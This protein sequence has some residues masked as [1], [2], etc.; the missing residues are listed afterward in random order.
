MNRRRIGVLGL[1][2]DGAS[3]FQRGP[4]EAPAAIRQA[5]RS[6]HSNQWAERGFDTGAAEAWHDLGDLALPDDAA[7]CR[8]AVEA[9]VARALEQDFTPLLLGGDHS[10]SYPILRAF[11]G[12][13]GS[14]Q[15][16]HFDAHSDLYDHLEGDRYSHACPFAR[17]LE[18]GLAAGMT[19][20]GIRTMNGHQREQAERFGVKVHYASE[21][22]GRMDLNPELPIYV[23][24]DVD[25]LDP[26]FAPGVSNREAGGLSTRELI[27]ALRRISGPVIGADL[28][29][30]NPRTDVAGLTAVVTG[31]L[32]KEM[33]G[34]LLE[35]GA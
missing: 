30:F 15:I 6:Q 12:R 28:V 33:I 17:V 13:R 18:E 11:K 4:A 29:E 3:S 35:C 19:Q 7:E 5:F 20:V 16:L 27:D 22:D 8:T 10:L 26:A 2:W 23:S 24:L 9:G 21:W 31:K 1:P 34:L 32:F 25:V 14:F